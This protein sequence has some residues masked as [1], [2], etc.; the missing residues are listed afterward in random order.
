MAVEA[1]MG[2]GI[3]V[4]LVLAFGFLVY[5]K[6]DLRQRQLLAANMNGS[7]TSEEQDLQQAVQ[8]QTK[9]F[10]EFSTSATD[11]LQ[12]K[13]PLGDSND[14]P[15]GNPMFPDRETDSVLGGLESGQLLAANNAAETP[16]F[17]AAGTRFNDLTEPDVEPTSFHAS[18]VAGDTPPADFAT[19]RSSEPEDPFPGLAANETQRQATAAAQSPATQPPSFDSPKEFP[20]QNPFPATDD[21]FGK[22]T[23][24]ADNA[25][26]ASPFPEEVA[27]PF[28]AF[29]PNQSNRIQAD[30]PMFADSGNAA[31]AQ[32]VDDFS[33]NTFT[34]GQD[35]PEEGSASSQQ[36]SPA[37]AST[38]ITEAAEPKPLPFA[39]QEDEQT[40]A[41]SVSQS[42]A[43]DSDRNRPTATQP[44]LFP[45]FPETDSSTLPPVSDAGP[46]AV[47][48][49]ERASE[50]PLLTD[51]LADQAINRFDSQTQPAE[52][53]PNPFAE[54]RPDMRNAIAML[55]P[56]P[57]VNLFE[58]PIQRDAKP[59]RTLPAAEEPQ[60]PAAEE[61]S[62]PSFP[63]F[64]TKPR[65]F[66]PEPTM[67]TFP[68][69]SEPPQPLT[70]PVE[71]N[72]F[73]RTAEPTQRIT[74]SDTTPG[75]PQPRDP[76]PFAQEPQQ[77]IV[78]E[79][80][81]S[82]PFVPQ[83]RDATFSQPSQSAPLDLTPRQPVPSRPYEPME[84]PNQGQVW[85]PDVGVA[86]I[87]KA[88]DILLTSGSGAEC[89]ICEV[90]PK[91]NYWTISKRAYGTARYFSS[92]ALYNKER[93]PD[94]KKLRPGM[95]VLIPHPQ[96]LEKK[97]P[98]F[99]AKAKPT[100]RTQP[101]GYF[102][103][104]DGKPA[105]RVGERETLSEISHKHLGRASRWIQIYQMNRQTLR[106]P[107]KL[108]PGIVISLPDDAT[109]VQ[110]TP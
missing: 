23:A 13:L 70:P 18:D 20:E 17:G 108:K 21:S 28:P 89:E 103:T 42:N 8:E 77:P 81:A 3:I 15:V 83:P 5:H 67:E 85:G 46:T 57:D 41:R 102:I 55:E 44:D 33:N 16:A 63:G 6:F 97:Y 50:I 1:K 95:K 34:G 38:E 24:L 9:S 99:F 71:T 49:Q 107:N 10:D 92:L 75:V 80:F 29:D 104:S 22:E 106:D 40:E 96:V 87:L 53:T 32:P 4:I 58:D 68:T 14:A 79:P 91:D 82:E 52:P 19:N 86:H 109:N 60:L 74:Q 54:S 25:A 45:D 65:T 105:Y 88:D 73:P 48:A 47:A 69:A 39:T 51:T 7:A 100:S 78:Q 36:E 31:P 76:V 62:M 93:I 59:P 26:A 64:E 110:L 56:S 37:F 35:F 94:P 43:L 2:M 27:D 12:S 30:P 61:P 84:I 72:L 11:S 101:K 66:N 98:E 90:R